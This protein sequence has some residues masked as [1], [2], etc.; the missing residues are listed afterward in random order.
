M[1][2]LLEHV[3]RTLHQNSLI[4]PGSRVVV[5]LSGGADSVALTVLLAELSSDGAFGIASL[6]HLNHCLRARAADEDE[7]FCRA[8]AADLRLPIQVDRVDVGALARANRQ[9][10][11]EAGREVR[12]RFF[13]RVADLTRADR[14]AVG[15]TLEDQAETFLLNLLR[16]AGSR[17]LSG[18][19]MKAGRVVRPLLDVGHADLRRFLAE[20]GQRHREDETNQD[21]RL[22]RNRIR[23]LVIPFLEQQFSP[24]VAAVLAR[25][26]A[27][28]RE[29]AA[30]LDAEAAQ[31]WTRAA[32]SDGH[33]VVLDCPVLSGEPPALARRVALRALETASAGRFVGFDHVEALLSMVRGEARRAADFP[34]VRVEGD[35]S[36]VTLRPRSGP[37]RGVREVRSGFSCPLPVPGAAFIGEIGMTITAEWGPGPADSSVETLVANS[38]GRIAVVDPASA[39]V[40]L[41]VRSRRAGDRFRPLGLG[42]TKKLQ[43]F[44][45]DRKVVARERDRIPL[46]VDEHD[47][48]IWVAGHAICEDFR[49]TAATAAVVILRLEDRGDQA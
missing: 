14:I 19:P 38:S 44:L 12:Y 23:H 47:R 45:V 30:W 3:R 48:I 7:A 11:E 27:I 1:P 6:A 18:M 21:T 40:P 31:A 17:G 4:P 29:N 46:V 43:D 37:G 39:G 26:A 42:G 10:I 34:G 49:V 13:D 36:R 2:S 41:R 20:R 35:G 33:S 9:S 32:R 24:G 8:L 16:G 5:G 25:N 22:L 28:A 15:H